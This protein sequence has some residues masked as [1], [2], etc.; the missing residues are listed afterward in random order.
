MIYTAHDCQEP[1]EVHAS[2]RES[3][4]ILIQLFQVPHLILLLCNIPKLFAG[5]GKSRGHTSETSL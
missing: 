4:Y 5:R 2:S 1:A 3:I